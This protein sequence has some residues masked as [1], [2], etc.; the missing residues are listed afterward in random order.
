MRRD[1][2]AQVV[3][4]TIFDD[5]QRV[6]E[7]GFR[8]HL[9]RLASA[10][11]DICV[12]GEAS[13]EA[14]SLTPSEV[15]HVLAVAAD[16]VKDRVRLCA[17]GVA[18]RTA[19][20]ESE[21]ITRAEAAGYDYVGIYPLDLGH[22]QWPTEQELE[23]YYNA[24][25]S[26][27]HVSALLSYNT[28]GYLIRPAL[29]EKLVNRFANVVEIRGSGDDICYLSS[30]IEAV[31]P[32]V[33]VRSGGPQHALTNLALGGVG[34][35]CSEGNVA[36]RLATEIANRYMAG[37]I[38]GTAEVFT[39]MIGLQKLHWKYGFV[40]SL[41]AILDSSG[42]PGGPPRPPRL[43]VPPEQLP[44]LISDF[45]RLGLYE[46]EQFDATVMSES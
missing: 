45:K 3:A 28:S 12:A 11:V 25:L 15:E 21:F 20:Q 35:G 27:T 9:R 37:D 23:A 29:F 17:L 16:E 22:G 14:H 34:F 13:S 36:P 2:T 42:L 10:G 33:G 8:M 6:D 1:P 40:R 30:M 39:K 43:P 18:P 32:R 41:K 31:G 38:P 26:R 44:D 19:Q 7:Q 46:I 24:V 4:L 5:E